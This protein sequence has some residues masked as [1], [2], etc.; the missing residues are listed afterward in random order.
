MTIPSLSDK[1]NPPENFISR[2]INCARR[3][4]LSSHIH[5]HP[6]MTMISL[7]GYASEPINQPTFSL[8]PQSRTSFPSLS[9]LKNSCAGYN[10]DH[11]SS[12]A[13]YLRAD[14]PRIRP[15]RWCIFYTYLVSDYS[16]HIG[17]ITYLSSLHASGHATTEYFMCPFL[18][19]LAPNETCYLGV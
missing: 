11:S 2:P 12:F 3:I 6:T 15:R 9:F 13:Q 10:P 7:P 18:V 14:S 16:R 8:L 4:S 5:Y 19:F 17:D 1:I